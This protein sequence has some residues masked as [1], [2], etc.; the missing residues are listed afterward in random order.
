MFSGLRPKIE[1]RAEPNQI[2]KQP[3]GRRPSAHQAA[4][5]LP[6][7]P[8]D[9]LF[10]SPGAKNLNSELLNIFAGK[11]HKTELKGHRTK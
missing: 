11:F 7:L 8:R 10:C 9:C 4:E 1:I 3:E 5:P 2:S 6:T